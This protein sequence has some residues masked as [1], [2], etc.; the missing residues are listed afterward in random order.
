MRRDLKG[1]AMIH[2]AF[3]LLPKGREVIAAKAA[4][5][6]NR[7]APGLDFAPSTA[8]SDGEITNLEFK[9]GRVMIVPVPMPVP[10]G[11]A[12]QGFQYSIASWLPTFKPPSHAAHVI[13]TLRLDQEMTTLNAH[14]L[15][16]RVLAAV[17]ES[18]EA[19][20][21]YWGSARVTHPADFF[22][23]VANGDDQ[24][25]TMLWTGVSAVRQGADRLSMLSLGMEQF[26]LMDA[27]VTGPVQN[28]N[29]LLMFMMDMLRYC[30]ERG[31]AIP[32]GDTVG[33]TNQERLKV[34]HVPSP[35]DATRK[36]WSVDIP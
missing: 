16:T 8:A 24:L 12:D 30:I 9:G 20:G 19:A 17:V 3:V 35:I 15:F 10:K 36:V 5:A 22:L 18:T 23:D 28:A 27:L 32:H 34:K 2:M 11:E 25:W 7:R 33:R 14:L 1:D 4:S 13:V 26:G 21:V 6:L 29:D 31:S